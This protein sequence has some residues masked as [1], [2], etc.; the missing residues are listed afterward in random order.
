MQGL[1][2]T[3]YQATSLLTLY[4]KAYLGSPLCALESQL[5]LRECSLEC[6]H[7][8]RVFPYYSEEA[9]KQWKKS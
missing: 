4:Q 2:T 3:S 1:T 8:D 5:L 6:T 9:I 7:D